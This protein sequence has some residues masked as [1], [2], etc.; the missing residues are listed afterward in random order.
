MHAATILQRAGRR[1]T[2][3]AATVL[4]VD[5]VAV[6]LLLVAAW[7]TT[8][9]T[10][11]ADGIVCLI[12]FG[13]QI[14]ALLL[15]ARELADRDALTSAASR[16]YFARATE[17][18]LGA[19]ARSA[20]PVSLA[21]LDCDDFKQTNE[22]FGHQVGDDILIEVAESLRTSVAPHGTVARLW[23]DAFGILLPGVPLA[24]AR[25]LL[26]GAKARLESRMSER[27]APM[28]F[29]IGLASRASHEPVA[30]PEQLLADADALMFAVKRDGR[31]G[32]ACR[33]VEE[34]RTTVDQRPSPEFARQP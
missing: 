2:D 9:A 22:R 30:T 21:V 11:L 16:A 15:R 32:I 18:A 29:S 28:T 13:C 20:R 25:A 5:T 12:L 7:W 10:V 24:S 26:E 19:S 31:N 17:R 27:G 8:P 3:H 23:G 14:A 1:L 4:I 33:T 6:C 34:N